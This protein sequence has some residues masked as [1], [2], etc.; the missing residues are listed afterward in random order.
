M[1]YVLTLS[2]AFKQCLAHS[3]LHHRHHYHDCYSS[4]PLYL[5]IPVVL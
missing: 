4:I 5:E 3:E 2:K 1:D